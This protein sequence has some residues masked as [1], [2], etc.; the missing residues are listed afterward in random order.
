MRYFSVL[1]L[2]SCVVSVRAGVVV[3]VGGVDGLPSL[4]AARDKVRE[5]PRG[6]AITVEIAPG[7]YAVTEALELDARDSGREGAP[8]TWRAARPGT[9]VFDGAQRLSLAKARRCEP[10]EAVRR[11]CPAAR[12]A[13]LVMPVEDVGMQE[14]LERPSPLGCLIMQ[15]DELLR[16]ARFPNKGFA[17]AREEVI[18]DGGTRWETHPVT[19]TWDRP[20]GGMFTLRE[21]PAGTWQQWAD[22]V[23]VHR[24]ALA[25]GYLSSQWMRETATLR[26]VW[27]ERGAIRFVNKTRYGLEEMITKFQSRQTY[28]HLLCELDSPGEWY[29][30][31]GA[32]QFYLWPAEPVTAASTLMVGAAEG[33]LEMGNVSHV[34]F[35]GC[36]VQ[37]IARGACFVVGGA[38]NEINGCTVRDCLATAFSVQG[39]H[40]TV[41]GCDAYDVAAFARVDGGRATQSQ[42]TPGNNRL[43][44][45]HFYLDKL[46]GV[47]AGVGIS[48]VGN[49]LIGNLMHN[50]GGQAIVFS[51]NDHRIER[52][53]VFNVGFEEGDGAAIYSGA[54]FWG[55]GTRLQHNFIHHVMNTDGLMTRAGIMLDDH[56]SGRE[57]VENIFYKAGHGALAVN[58]GTGH[59]IRRNIFME[60]NMGVWVRI[61]GNPQERIDMEPKFASGAMRRG[62]KHDYVWRC[63]QVVGPQGWNKGI[64]KEKYPV[65]ATVMNQVGEHGRFWPIENDVDGNLGSRMVE[66]LVFR[67]PKIAESRLVFKNTREID[68]AAVFV[69]AAALDFRW[70]GPRED[71][72]PAIPV[73]EIGLSLD[74]HRRSM[75]DKA[76][77]RRLVSSHFA[78]RAACNRR[79]KYN[80]ERVNELIYW[81]SG[82]LLRS[83]A[84]LTH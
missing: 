57:I 83:G 11:L 28:V 45:C 49:H 73:G 63:E 58:G 55:Y 4:V 79:A 66:A 62:D 8:V 77:Y 60:G 54:Q 36:T 59:V 5:L 71:W 46:D 24:R 7:H 52:N 44:N 68:P 78:G 3:R 67:H 61:L 69:D 29:Y 12:S 31:V 65:F 33:F 32:R 51:G 6:E 19:G 16:V 15:G 84:V 40:N 35:A 48:G 34:R 42:I 25:T 64:W 14:V 72:M 43:M 82:A 10:A 17:H 47:A 13:V 80:F 38:H 26:T 37:G 70:K 41:Q 2:L 50:L 30:D 75:P 74:A 39:M 76:A 1:F 18:H 21:K 56:D 23:A 22:E 20:N 81:N 27:P 53:E 9:V